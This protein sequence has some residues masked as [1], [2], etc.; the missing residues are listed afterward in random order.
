MIGKNV[1]KKILEEEKRIP[2]LYI[3]SDCES[4]YYLDLFTTCVQVRK[5]PTNVTKIKPQPDHF[6][7]AH[8]TYCSILRISLLSK[9]EISEGSICD[10]NCLVLHYSRMFEVQNGLA[11][12]R[13]ILTKQRK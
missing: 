6:N 9:Y 2:W 11:H 10:I 7:K 5:G 12:S 13:K 1:V 8:G 3:G 4:C